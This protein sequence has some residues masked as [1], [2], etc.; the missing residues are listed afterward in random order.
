M[1]LS[2]IKN[3]GLYCWFT[4]GLR[5]SNL[6]MHPFGPFRFDEHDAANIISY[7]KR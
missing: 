4:F 1:T 7:I 2:D 3:Q 5:K 6:F